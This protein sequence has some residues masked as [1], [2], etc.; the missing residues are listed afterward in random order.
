[1]TKMCK[2]RRVILRSKFIDAEEALSKIK[3]NIK[4]AKETKVRLKFEFETSNEFVSNQNVLRVFTEQ[5]TSLSET[6]NYLSSL[7]E[8]IR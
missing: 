1:M 7:C 3:K 6:E 2:R 5:F 8:T 4:L